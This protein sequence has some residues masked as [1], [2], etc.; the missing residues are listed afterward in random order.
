MTSYREAATALWGQAGAYIHDSYARS[1]AA[2][3]PHLPEQVPIVIAERMRCLG[4]A[5]PAA[6]RDTPGIV[7]DPAWFGSLPAAMKIALPSG[8]RMVDDQLM[9]DML[10]LELARRGTG[11]RD[12]SEAW[13]GLAEELSPEVLGRK[14]RLPKDAMHPSYRNYGPEEVK[15]TG[16]PYDFR[17][18]SYSWGRAI[19]LPAWCR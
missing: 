12:G 5:D 2:Y 15:M 16:W 18:G 1:R 13:D 14:L 4:T 10:H 8:A 19:P 3:F 7:I 6:L 9:H 17:P 11:H